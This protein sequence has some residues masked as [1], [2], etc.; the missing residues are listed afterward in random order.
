MR[1]TGKSQLNLEL[2]AID[3]A[4]TDVRY[5]TDRSF[6]DA[7]FANVRAGEVLLHHF[8]CGGEEIESTVGL[9]RRCGDT[10]SFCTFARLGA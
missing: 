10:T 8:G 1:R 3:A 2:D 9:D 6:G 4:L 7:R 5:S